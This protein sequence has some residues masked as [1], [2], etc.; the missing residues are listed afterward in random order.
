MIKLLSKLYRIGIYTGRII[1]SID[2]SIDSEQTKGT[3]VTLKLP[4]ISYEEI[5]GGWICL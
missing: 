3:V 5:Q 4:L 2:L 1:V